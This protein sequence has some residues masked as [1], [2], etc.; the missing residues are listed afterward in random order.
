MMSFLYA[1]DST[2]VERI[3]TS[4]LIRPAV[5]RPQ[6][7]CERDRDHSFCQMFIKFGL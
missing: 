2:N 3:L 6:L 4:P 5:R 1:H 7:A